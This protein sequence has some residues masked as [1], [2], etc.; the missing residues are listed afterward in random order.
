MA[1]ASNSKPKLVA[2]RTDALCGECPLDF[3][4][5]SPVK[6]T[7]VAELPGKIAQA[8][9]AQETWASTPLEQRIWRL[10]RAAKAMLARR[11]EV[12]ELL[13]QEIGKL[14][15][16]ALM[17]EALGP[18]DQVN[19]WA[20]VVRRELRRRRARLN[21]VS[22]PRKRAHYDLVPRGVIGII[23]PW[24]YPQATLFRSVFPALL[25]GNAVVLKPS[26]YAPRTAMWFGDVLTSALGQNLV[27]VVPGAGDV[28]EALLSAGIDACVFTGS[29]ATGKKVQVRCAELGIPVSAE[30]GG[31]DPALVLPDCD[32]DRTVMGITHWALHN[33]GQACSAI[34]VAYV[35]EQIA[36]L[37]VER[38]SRAWKKLRVGP[39]P[40]AE[41]DVSPLANRR[42]LETC[43]SHIDD[44]VAQ[45]ATLVCGGKATGDGLWLAPT[46]LDR[47]DEKMRVVQEETFG[48]V[49]AVVRVT[50]TADAIE[51][52]N[53]LPY[54]L[55][56]SLWTRDLLRAE[57]LAERLRYG[58]VTV[59]NH[60]LTGAMPELPWSGQRHTGFAVANSRL[61]L[62]TFVR[63]R[64]LLVDHAKK[65][66]PFWLPFDKT[67][68][69]LG[70]ILADAQLA[71]IERAWRLPG[72]LAKRTKRI[73]AFFA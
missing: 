14:E 8:R 62:T 35:D 27:T 28:G 13:R 54:G 66:E 22:F 51:R 58:V 26:E 25:C 3:R 71:R 56:A 49:L 63:P 67:L 39:G 10:T 47:C 16:D 7:A 68:W 12:I 29:V 73:R 69:L 2:P 5:L 42:Q 46:L 72:L 30:L 37:F 52:A 41:V 44:A 64:T 33:A 38:L 60:S 4:P 31:K 24:N 20:K 34:E 59:N 65:P 50:G 17:S 40:F 15:V 32:L 48:P 23:S 53:A 1:K 61:S 43:L 36:D 19:G 9:L 11:A 70:D 57:R 21:P 18:L 6:A 55:T 45:G